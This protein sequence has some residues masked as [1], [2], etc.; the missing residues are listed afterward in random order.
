M[1]T[2]EDGFEHDRQACKSIF[3]GHG[4]GDKK[5]GE[6][7]STLEQYDYHFS[8]GPKHVEKLRE[9]GLAIPEERLIKIGNLRFDDYLNGT[10]DR[11]RQ[12]DTL[13]IQDRSRR[14]VLYAPTWKFG[15][16][17]FHRWVYPF[18][19][20]I[21][22]R[23]NLIVRPHFHDRRSLR[24][25]KLWARLHRIKHVYFSNPATVVGADAMPGFA[26]SDLLIS[27]TSSMLYEYLVTRK[28]IV[29]IQSGYDGLHRMPGEMDIMEC[30]RVFDGS[31]DILQV[32]AAALADKDVER[33]CARLLHA[34]F[35]FNDGRSV[36][37]AREFI[38]S[39]ADS[40]AHRVQGGA[41]CVHERQVPRR[42]A[43]MP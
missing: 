31:Q 16:G 28:P 25:V 22:K 9:Q 42:G 37:R 12:L 38:H 32:I 13:G 8:S 10:C 20:E 2:S 15:E 1:S 6:H 41:G 19:T 24:R 17:T 27:D 33:K 11:E 18:A 7:A 30:A 40:P 39:L 43:T 23:Y 34:C 14:N 4:S 35:Y 36:E 21:T 26:A 29:V 5:Y 3:V